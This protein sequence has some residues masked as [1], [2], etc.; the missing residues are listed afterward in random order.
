M[1]YLQQITLM[2]NKMKIII[3]VKFCHELTEYYM[4]CDSYDVSIS[5]VNILYMHP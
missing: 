5:K 4:V 2:Y 3:V 1:F